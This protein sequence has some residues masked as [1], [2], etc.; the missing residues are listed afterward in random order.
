MITLV[1]GGRSMRRRRAGPRGSR[2]H[3]LGLQPITAT[4]PA[5][6]SKE[7]IAD[8]SRSYKGG[9]ILADRLAGILAAARQIMPQTRVRMRYR[10]ARRAEAAVFRLVQNL[11][12]TAAS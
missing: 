9:E 8:A 10:D 7:V 1:L 12:L 5:M 11:S 3:G 4:P 6:P 2:Q